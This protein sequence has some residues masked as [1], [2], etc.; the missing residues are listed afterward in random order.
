MGTAF[1]LGRLRL[2]SGLILMAFVTTHLINHTLGLISIE[3]AEAG[4]LIFLGFWRSPVISEIFA[5][6]LILHMLLALVKLFSRDTLKMSF[7]EV[8]QLGL[9]PGNPDPVDYP[10]ARHRHPASLLR[11]RRYVCL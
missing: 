7:W 8:S 1:W 2:I 5:A 6:S 4:R 11:C 3:A 9:G 10:F